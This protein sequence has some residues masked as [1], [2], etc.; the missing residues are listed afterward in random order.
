[1][2]TDD[3]PPPAITAAADMLS[4]RFTEAVSSRG[5]IDWNSL[6]R[7]VLEAAA[8]A[9]RAQVIAETLARVEQGIADGAAEVIAQAVRD[10]RE[11]CARLAERR[12]AIYFELG[13]P[14]PDGEPSGMLPFADLLREDTP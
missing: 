5:L 13:E 11:R 2:T 7:A 10:E 9:I 4:I 1:M 6:A 14:D 8:P 12:N 3:L